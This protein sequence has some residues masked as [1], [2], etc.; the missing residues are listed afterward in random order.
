MQKKHEKGERKTLGELSLE[1]S[2]NPDKV[3]SIELQR[4]IQGDSFESEFLEAV[5]RGQKKYPG[6][7][8]VVVLNQR[9]RI[10]NNAMR[11][12]FIDRLSC[13]TPEYDQTVYHYNKKDDAID[14]LWVVPDKDTCEYAYSHAVT[15]EDEYR[16]LLQYVLDFYDGT[17]LKIAKRLNKEDK[18]DLVLTKH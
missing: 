12:Y 7:F 14:F 2:Q 11:C 6:D 3:D 5:A 1:L 13:P 10:M 9:F 4:E 17:L 16:E 8:Y 15:I 18:Q